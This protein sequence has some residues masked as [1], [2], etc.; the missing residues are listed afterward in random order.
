MI[1]KHDG[2][3]HHLTLVSALYC[4]LIGQYLP[5][6]ASDWPS[7]DDEREMEIEVFYL[8]WAI[9]E[10]GTCHSILALTCKMLKCFH[11]QLFKT[12]KSPNLDDS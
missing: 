8:R 2:T 5:V 1:A 3:S 10:G 4:L 6:Q 11:L 7:V 12:S 9:S